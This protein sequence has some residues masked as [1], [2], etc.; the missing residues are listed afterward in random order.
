MK[1]TVNKFWYRWLIV[2]TAGTALFGLEFVILPD[3]IHS[4]YSFLLFGTT[5]ARSILGENYQFVTF[6]YGVLGAVL[7]GWAISLL[8][9][10]LNGFRK[11]QSDAW[12]A[13]TMSLALWYVIDSGLS[14]YWGFSM[15][16]VFNTVFAVLFA[17][18]L[19]ATYRD[20]FPKGKTQE[21]V[22]A[23]E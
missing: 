16:A 13:I 21:R 4:L 9:I 20:F 7:F 8:I 12:L 23:T 3:A 22:L 18:P 11:G 14:V 19:V 2:V 17:I 6:V 15:N 1:N 5:D 10:L